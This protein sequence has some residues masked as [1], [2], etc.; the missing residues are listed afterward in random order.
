MPRGVKGEVVSSVGRWSLGWPSAESA[1]G[2]IAGF[3]W[4]VSSSENT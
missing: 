1:L 3:V 2:L 4:G